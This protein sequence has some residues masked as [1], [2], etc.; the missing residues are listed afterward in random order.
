CRNRP[1]HELPIG[2]YAS[3]CVERRSYSPHNVRRLGSLFSARLNLV[4]EREPI[5]LKRVLPRTYL[6]S[7]IVR[8]SDLRRSPGKWQCIRGLAVV[9]VT[10]NGLD[11][12]ALLSSYSSF[13]LACSWRPCRSG[14]HR[15]ARWHRRHG[16]VHHCRYEWHIH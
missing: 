13:P 11:D 4:Q 7:R 8:S 14:Y 9:P 15:T 10:N 6:Y 2:R 5:F 12:V 1:G 16:S 3:A